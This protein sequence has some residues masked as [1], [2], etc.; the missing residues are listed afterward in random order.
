MGGA[1]AAPMGGHAALSIGFF[2]RCLSLR[3]RSG[4]IRLVGEDDVPRRFLLSNRAGAWLEDHIFVGV[5]SGIQEQR[6][7]PDLYWTVPA[8]GVRT[9]LRGDRSLEVEREKKGPVTDRVPGQR[10]FMCSGSGN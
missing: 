5:I 1:V 8:P 9:R 4:F 3:R 6:T 7:A 10:A 2:L